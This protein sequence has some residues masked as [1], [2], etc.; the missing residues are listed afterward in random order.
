[1]QV[2]RRGL[3]L[4]TLI[5]N[6]GDGISRATIAHVDDMA[7]SMATIGSSEFPWLIFVD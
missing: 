7:P 3:V 1:M 4:P 5:A 2:R 6:A